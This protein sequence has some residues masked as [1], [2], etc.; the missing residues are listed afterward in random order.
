MKK[1][2]IP[3]LIAGSMAFGPSMLMADQTIAKSKVDE[4]ISAISL[5]NGAKISYGSVAQS[6]VSDS[7]TLSLIDVVIKD[8]KGKVVKIDK[9]IVHADSWKAEEK[10]SQINVKLLGAYLPIGFAIPEEI[11]KYLDSDNGTIKANLG[12]HYNFNKEN[13]T[14]DVDGHFAL[15]R[16]AGLNFHFV[17]KDVDE[18]NPLS[19][20]AIVQ[21]R[22]GGASINLV[23]TGL[24]NA[25]YSSVEKTEGMSKADLQNVIMA[26]V[27]STKE[28]KLTEDDEKSL[29]AFLNDGGTLS[30]DVQP[31]A[32]LQ[33][34]MLP[35]V[36]FNP[37]VMLSLFDLNFSQSN[38]LCT[39]TDDFMRCKILQH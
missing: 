39:Y 31:R 17:I 1:K 2:L 21:A 7:N 8:A 25:I 12:F 22:I 15:P 14:I 34:F 20:N 33:L 19:E 10:P 32:A 28:L 6:G 9:M 37:G 30:L 18:K 26:M 29:V 36:G 38:S 27:K 16:M 3:L 13:K 23:D 11:G 5:S 4:V 35:M 24:G